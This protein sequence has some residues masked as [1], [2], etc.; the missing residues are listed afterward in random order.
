MF[1]G[2]I[3]MYHS[4]LN[5]YINDSADSAILIIHLNSCVINA[6]ATTTFP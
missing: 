6:T 4:S 3:V 5:I 2:K 1:T